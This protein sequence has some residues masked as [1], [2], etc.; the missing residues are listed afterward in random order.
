MRKLSTIADVVSAQLCSGCG[1][2]A[3]MSPDEIE[4][5]DVVD[6]G[7]RPRFR[8]WPSVD[9]RSIEAMAACPGIELTHT[10]DVNKA[11][12]I[13][14]L[15]PEWGPVLQVL[16]GH[17]S[18]QKLRYAASSGG[19]ASAL[20]LYCIEREKMKGVLHISARQDIPY[21][22]HTIFSR[23]RDEIM[24]TVGSRYSPASPGEGLKMIEDENGK[25]VFI[26]KPCDVAGLS[27]VR[28][29][30][31]GLDKNIGVTISI[32][33]AGTPSL[34][35][36]LEMFKKMGIDDISKI[37]SVSYRGNGWPGKAAVCIKDG[38]KEEKRE[39]SYHD[40]WGTILQKYRPWRC[41]LCPEHTGEF[42]DVAVGD[43]WYRQISDDEQG[44]SLMLVRTEAGRRIVDGAIAADFIKVKNLDA[45]ILPESQKGMVR[46]RGAVWARLL[47]CRFLHIASPR[48]HNIPM[49]DAWRRG[50][51]LRQKLRS[52]IGVAKQLI[53]RRLYKSRG[54]SEYNEK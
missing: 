29:L 12:L 4:M 51:T 45:H 53:K 14:E 1:V 41:Y 37:K 42:A 43:P 17:A 27:R 34:R 18:D 9:K 33:C 39:M 44:Y 20:S 2:C 26:G 50:L 36:T 10:F 49:F 30:R 8:K 31:P 24:T 25:S 46:T 54:I 28:T 19:V 38:E 22:N 23:T 11:G 32:F 5:V 35:G 47:A 40:S 21:L 48:Y 15:I 13:K 16:E 3:Y 7:R 6:E 52:F